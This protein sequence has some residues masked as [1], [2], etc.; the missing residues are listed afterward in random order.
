[1]L[2]AE[3]LLR[4]AGFDFADQFVEAASEIL[5][6][7]LPRLRPF[8]EDGEILDAP[9]QRLAQVP[10]LLEAAAA[11]QQLLRP[12]LVL[13]EIRIGNAQL[14]PGELVGGTRGVKDSSADRPRAWRGPDTGGAA[15]RVEW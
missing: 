8:D 15:R 13:P 3:H 7:R 10:I 9:A 4:L 14:Y 11:L 5:G 2:A 12:G 6:D 1:V